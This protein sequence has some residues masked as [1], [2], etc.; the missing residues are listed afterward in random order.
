MEFIVVF[1]PIAVYLIFSTINNPLVDRLRKNRGPILFVT[2]ACTILYFIYT[3][4]GAATFVLPILFLIVAVVE[5][6][7]DVKNTKNK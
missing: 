1:F 6:V 3:N 4:S 5:W 2:A 7:T